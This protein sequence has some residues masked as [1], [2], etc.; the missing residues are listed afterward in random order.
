ML[1]GCGLPGP[2]A[3]GTQPTLAP[4]PTS[5]PPAATTTPVPFARWTTAQVI[6]AFQAY[7]CYTSEVSPMTKRDYGQAPALAAEGVKY[8]L[9]F[10][11]QEAADR[12]VRVLAFDN[13]SDLDQTLRYYEGLRTMAPGVEGWNFSRGNILVRISGIMPETPAREYEAALQTLP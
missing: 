3:N 8:Q 12:L 5:T 2:A 6:A 9:L 13:P 1:A 11:G 4:G 10:L 7:G